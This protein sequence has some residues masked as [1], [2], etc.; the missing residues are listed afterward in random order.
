MLKENKEDRAE[1][2][3]KI[4]FSQYP[5]R[6][7]TFDVDLLL[8][9][10]AELVDNMKNGINN[11]AEGALRGAEG[12]KNE[13]NHWRSVLTVDMVLSALDGVTSKET[14]ILP[15]QSLPNDLDV[16]KFCSLLTGLFDGESPVSQVCE[17]AK[18]TNMHLS[19]TGHKRSSVDFEKHYSSPKR[20]L[21]KAE[22]ADLNKK[23]SNNTE[24]IESEPTL[25]QTAGSLLEQNLKLKQKENCNK[26]SLMYGS[27]K[28]SLGSRRG[29]R[30]SFVPPFEKDSDSS[31]SKSTSNCDADC[32]L[33]SV[34][35]ERLKQLDQKIIDMIM[36]EIMDSK[37]SITWDDIAGLEFSKKTLQEIVILPMLRPDL[38]VGLRGPPKGLLLF[39][40]PGTGKTLIGKCIASQSNST[41]FSIS[42]SS[43]TSKWVGEGEKLV[44]ALFLVA[45]IHQPS[46]IFIDEVDSLLTQRSETEHESSRRIKTE[47][48][49][50]LDG[51]TT[52]E[53]ERILFIGATNRPQELDEAARR[54]FVKRLYIPLPTRSARKQ[55]V[56]RLL[57][58]NH[59]TLKEEDFWDIADRAD[60]YSGADMA[61]LCREAAMG[62][63]RSL[64][65][66]AIQ[67]IACD[68]VRPVELT[69]FHAAF[70][71]VR[72]SNSSH[73]LEQYLKWNSQYGSFET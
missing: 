73:D 16:A 25:F 66:E 45:R 55:I 28:R 48:L 3:R 38:F 56:Q 39:G 59:H 20:H 50:Q 15:K 36:S 5:K 72:A 26:V 70:R 53:D 4:L 27:S 33:E 1:Y 49:V 62:P 30:S 29:V 14:C 43:L 32:K 24:M 21:E 65:I 2:I 19:T 23:S 12:C 47:F 71:Q 35:D 52:S 51:I 40:P 7:N 37:S 63:I 58:Q 10:Y 69:D 34:C 42:S 9:E 6:C 67:H 17:P 41:F 18:N 60:G 46:V 13:S 11:Y 54:R 68:E 8:S 44:R 64:T 22:S 31:T 57:Q 61:N